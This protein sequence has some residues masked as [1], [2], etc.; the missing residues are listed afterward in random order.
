MFVLATV[1]CAGLRFSQL[2]PEAKDF[3]PKKIAVFPAEILNSEGTKGAKEV[4]ENIIADSLAE[5]K[6][7]ANIVN[8]ESL[9]KQIKDNQELSNVM[10]EYLSKL[11]IPFSD[12]DLSKKIGDLTNVEA[13]LMVNVDDWE[14]TVEKDEKMA[15]V[16]MTMQLYDASTGKLI[17]KAGYDIK[18]SYI[19]IK[20]ALPDVA[21]DVVRK[22]IS[23]MP[24]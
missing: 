8:A 5:K 24:H 9:N 11:R 13:F 19:V 21:R 12:P 18:K 3:H 1:A 14:Y 10:T 22:M 20:P 2:A 7:F 23:S 4:V 16:G 6:W 17:W 15:K